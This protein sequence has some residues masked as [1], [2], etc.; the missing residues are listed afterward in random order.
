MEREDEVLVVG[1][2]LY[3]HRHIV[4]SVTVTVASDLAGLGTHCFSSCYKN[5]ILDHLSR[6]FAPWAASKR[7]EPP[8]HTYLL[9]GYLETDFLL[10]WALWLHE[11]VA[12]VLEL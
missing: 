10:L 8:P 12:F 4:T 2:H 3:T 1:M 9:Q 6:V 7:H 5:A 11:G